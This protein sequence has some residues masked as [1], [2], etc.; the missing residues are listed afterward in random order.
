MADL[1]A[2]GRAARAEAIQ[3]DTAA[4]RRLMDIYGDVY[5]SLSGELDAITDRIR[6]AR[7]A[8]QP[9]TP[10]MLYQ[11]GRL[12]ALR[13]Q[14][15]GQLEQAAE[16]AVPV[17]REAVGAARSQAAATAATMV[18]AVTPPTALG[19][20]TVNLPIAAVEA[21][22]SFTAQ[23]SPLATLFASIAPAGAEAIERAI[24]TAVASGTNPRVVAREIRQAL[25][26]NAVRAMTI[27]RTEI[28]RAHREGAIET[29]RQNASTI[30]GWVWVAGLGSRT[31]ASCWAQSGTEHPLDEPMASHPNCRCVAAPLTVSWRD[32][33][34]DLPEPD[35]VPYGPDLFAS[36]KPDLQRAVLGP[37]R[38]EAY[39]RGDVRLEDFVARRQ[40]AQWGASTS[41]AGL[42]EARQN[43][44]VR[45][46]A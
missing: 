43:A 33:G 20:G 5:R 40:S 16:R 32:L 30:R 24:I 12:Q 46:A 15:L 21:A 3:I 31:C 42:T 4:S 17:V 28:M 29:Y 36:S 18:E 9:V 34:I 37:S 35:P 10:A 7:A 14:A 22:A 38:Y 19:F 25:G 2:L 26:G 27:S 44:A 8:G 1:Y 13:A 6:A 41:E 23:G 39:R 11:E 45:Q